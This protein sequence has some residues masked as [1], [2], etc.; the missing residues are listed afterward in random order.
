MPARKNENEID[1]EI[2][3]NT[4]DKEEL[5]RIANAIIDKDKW[6]FDRLAE[7]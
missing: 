4:M 1:E 7:I 3:E 6:A 5:R 2:V